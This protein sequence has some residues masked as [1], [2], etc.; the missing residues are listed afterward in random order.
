MKT[1]VY[2]YFIR[3]ITD[4]LRDCS[5]DDPEGECDCAWYENDGRNA[6]PRYATC[7]R[8]LCD[9]LWPDNESIECH[10]GLTEAYGPD[11]EPLGYVMVDD[12]A[13]VLDVEFVCDDCLGE[14]AEDAAHV[15]DE[16]EFS[17]ASC[18]HCGSHLGGS[19]TEIWL[20]PE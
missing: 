20:A 12:S 4:A 10:G 6:D 5:C 8:A 7:D 13:P 16:S 18:D 19:R 1:Q 17:W 2:R 11:G 14:L 3:H 15:G 9:E